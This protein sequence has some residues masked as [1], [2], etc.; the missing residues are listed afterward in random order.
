MS[1]VLTAGLTVELFHEQPYTNAPWPSTVKG[2]D[3]LY[4]LPE[5]WPKY[6]LTYSLLARKPT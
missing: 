4:R 2:G 1:S 5:G 6:P 3:G